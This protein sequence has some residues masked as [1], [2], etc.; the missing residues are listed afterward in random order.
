MKTHRPLVMAAV[1]AAM[2]MIAIEATIV[3]T[4]MPQ[5]AAQLGDLHLYSWVFSAFLLSQ[6]ATTVIFGKLADLYG[7]RPVVLAGIAVFL[8]GS[9]LCGFAWSMPSLILFRLLQGIGGGA[10]QP[11]ALTVVGDLYPGAERAKVQ[12]YLASVWGIS[13]I[14]GPLA[15]GLITQNFSWSWVFWINLPVGLT[16][17]GLFLAFLREQPVPGTR[18]VDAAGAALFAVAVAALMIAL[19]VLGTAHVGV[20]VAAVALCLVSAILFVGQERRCRDPMIVFDLW[21]HR[22]IAIA[23]AASLLSGMT[24]I[25]LTTFLPMYV[26]AVLGRSA[27]LAGFALT[28]MVMGWPIASTIAAKNLKHLSLRSLLLIGAGLLPLGAFPYIVLD[29]VSALAMAG[30]GSLVM[31]FGMG[32]LSVSCIL[33]VQGC[34]GWAERGAATA[35]N[36]FARNLGSTLGATVLGGV[37]NISLAH[38]GNGVAID[39]DAIRQLIDHHGTSLVDPGLRAALAHGLDLTF[40]AMFLVAVLTFLVATLVPA[41]T[42][43][44]E[45]PPVAPPVASD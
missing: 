30:L 36:I 27:L 13:S 8:L 24:I 6:T 15:G 26:Q 25:G 4:A 33:I 38:Q 12:G 9:V 42:L 19:T 14:L 34:V 7:R 28:A 18:T 17:A 21:A 1:M 22:P 23:N 35:S 39:I 41:V 40:W 29:H 44:R 2:F 16:A 3:S 5:I 32:F 20:A 10:I 11:V 43:A 45:N 31:G 37:L